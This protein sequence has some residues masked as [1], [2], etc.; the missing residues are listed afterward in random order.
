[1]KCNES[2]STYVMANSIVN[3][4]QICHRSM[5]KHCIRYSPCISPKRVFEVVYFTSSKQRRSQGVARV[6]KATPNPL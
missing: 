5:I 1:M 3:R 4:V 6:V 2:V